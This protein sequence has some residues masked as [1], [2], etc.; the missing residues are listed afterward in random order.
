MM[1][2]NKQINKGKTWAQ[3]NFELGQGGLFR[4]CFDYVS[5]KRI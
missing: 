2:K 1:K 3:C 4:E 5:R